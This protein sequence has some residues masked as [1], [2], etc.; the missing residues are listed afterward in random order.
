MREEEAQH[1][2]RRVRSSRIGV[3]AGGTASRPC[4]AGTVNAP[5]LG[6]CLPARVGKDGTGISMPAGHP[7]AKDLRCTRRFGGL[8]ENSVAV[9]RVHRGV[10][11]AMENDGRHGRS[12]L[13]NCFGSATLPHGGERRGE[14]A[15][16]AADEARMNADGRV[17]VGVRR[18]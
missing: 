7:S 3:G 10:A 13:C 14:V 17:Q 12:G 5:M 4:V 8:L 9:V 11:I 6:N 15:G 16:G 18:P 1:F 2:P